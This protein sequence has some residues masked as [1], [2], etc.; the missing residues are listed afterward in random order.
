MAPKFEKFLISPDFPINFREIHQVS[1]NYLKCTKSYGQKP[2]GVPKDPPGLNRVKTYQNHYFPALFT[3]PRFTLIPRV[4]LLS[5]CCLCCL[6]L[7]GV[8]G[9]VRQGT[10]SE[11]ILYISKDIVLFKSQIPHCST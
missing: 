3:N 4:V 6:N 1:K 2:L 9:S 8:N 7:E 11:D 5:I 10:D